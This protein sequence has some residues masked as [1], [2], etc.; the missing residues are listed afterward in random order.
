MTLPTVYPAQYSGT[1]TDFAQAKADKSGAMRASAFLVTTP[2]VMTAA[3]FI[4][5]VPVKK[6]ARLVLTACRI[7]ND[8]LDSGNA[9][10]C[11]IGVVY[12]D[13][14][15]NT[16]VP[17]QYVAATNTGLQTAQTFT[18]LTTNAADTYVATGDGWV[19]ITTA[20]ASTTTVGTIHGVIT[21]TYD[22]TVM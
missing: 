8:D 11:S 16:S 3:T 18:L 13:T 12:N 2:A 10:T 5:L 6:G 20:T 1:T 9:V 15:N 17:A 14:V 7:S 4:G 22:L 21:I 19:G